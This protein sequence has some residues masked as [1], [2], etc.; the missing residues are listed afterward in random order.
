MQKQS[1]KYI[2]VVV[3]ISFILI[4]TF[5][6][7]QDI[8]LFSQKLTNSFI[9]N[10][11]L[12]GHTYGSVTF[13]H[14]KNFSSVT[15][16]ATSNFFSVHTPIAGHRMGIGGN[17]FI[18]K[19]NV[20]QNLYGSGAFA[21]HLPIGGY[22]VL[23][24]GVSA[25]YNSLKFDPND[26]IGDKNDD[27]LLSTNESSLDFSFGVNYQHKFFK[28]GA[29]VNRLATNLQITKNA[30]LLSEY[31]SGY[32]AGM[33]P[34]RG[35]E[36][37]IEP[38]FTFRKFS[39][40]SNVWDIGLYYTYDAKILV[41]AAYRKGDILSL[42][43]GFQINKKLLLGYSYEM[44]NTPLRGDLG[45]T[46]EITIRFDFN[47]RNYQDRFKSDYSNAMAFRRKT[48][49]KS[50]SA[51]KKVGVKGPKGLKK[52]SKQA[53]KYSP[54]RRY[55]KTNKLNTV[56]HKSFDSKSRRKQNYKRNQKKH[57]GASKNR[58]YR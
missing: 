11:A 27:L 57:K 22:N 49:S 45:A 34:L 24:M 18:E 39:D 12:A 1:Y 10:P 17:L 29:A 38:T 53:A 23:S 42:T 52:R 47:E 41:G 2:Q 8:P 6:F 40:V 25:E 5:S 30:G 48:L 3:L 7:S 37:L 9:Y 56:K 4:S 55:N 19:V 28:A 58:R 26:V 51:R 13:A 31:Y 35:D 44:V 33:L 16:S 43:G 21:Y 14:R 32:V 46:S 20:F 15:N 50:S 36:D 54:N